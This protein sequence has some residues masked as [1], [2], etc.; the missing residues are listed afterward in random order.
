MLNKSQ[1]AAV[2]TEES[3]RVVESS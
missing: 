1:R 2:N 3:A